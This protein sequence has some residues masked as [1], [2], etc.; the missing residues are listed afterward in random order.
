[1]QNPSPIGS[2]TA[3]NAPIAKVANPIYVGAIASIAVWALQTYAHTQIPPEVAIAMV[4]VLAGI[5][6]YATPLRPSEVRS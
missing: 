6:G 4:T 1:M 2:Q 5:V 3:I